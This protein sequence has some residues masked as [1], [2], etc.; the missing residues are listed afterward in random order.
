MFS[1]AGIDADF[2][3]CG[4]GMMA[5]I[6]YL[7]SPPAGWL[8]LHVCRTAARGWEWA[9]LMVDHGRTRA[10]WIRIPGRHRSADAAWDA[11][12]DMIATRH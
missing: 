9:G 10:A 7:D 2:R 3:A 5:T 4:N 11:L 6:T 12:Q 8:A 1:G